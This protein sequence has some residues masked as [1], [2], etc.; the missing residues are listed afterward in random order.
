[1]LRHFI[2]II[3]VRMFSLPNTKGMSRRFFEDIAH[4]S[5]Y[6]QY[7]PRPPIQLANRIVQYLKEKVTKSTYFIT[8]I[9]LSFIS[10]KYEG[11]L[12]LCLDVGCGNGQTSDL[13]SP[14]FSRVLATDISPAQIQ[15]AKSLNHPSGIEFV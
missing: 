1:M 7:R 8:F 6:A 10:S 13:F 5:L 14:Y 12:S 2:N 11:D 3:M 9:S 4:A 15:V